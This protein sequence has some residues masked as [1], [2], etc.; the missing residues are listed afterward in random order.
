MLDK[1][2]DHFVFNEARWL[3][4]T[5]FLEKIQA[6]SKHEIKQFKMHMVETEIHIYLLGSWLLLSLIWKEKSRQII[7]AHIEIIP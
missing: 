3:C 4:K 1:N 5:P 2:I 6:I 7:L